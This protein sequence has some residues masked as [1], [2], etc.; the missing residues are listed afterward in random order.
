[1]FYNDETKEGEQDLNKMHEIKKIRQK[2]K[3]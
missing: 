1:M 3:N 2:Y